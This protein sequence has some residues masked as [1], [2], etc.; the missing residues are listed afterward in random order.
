MEEYYIGMLNLPAFSGPDDT[1]VLISGVC[2]FG[3]YMGSGDWWL[4]QIEVPF[5]EMFGF[6]PTLRRSHFYVYIIYVL[7]ISMII[8]GSMLKF[9]K[10]RDE[11]H[12]KNRFTWSSFVS[13]GGYMLLN[14]VVYNT[15]GII[16]GSDIL[17]THPR[18]VVFCFAG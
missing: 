10:A 11:T 12:F 8:S 2:L 14:V 1:S 16:C 18:S 6:E 13:H 9:W 5:A 7:E 4:E 17:K 15:Y 3:A